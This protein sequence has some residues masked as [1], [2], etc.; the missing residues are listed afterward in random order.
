MRANDGAD[1]DDDYPS[2]EDPDEWNDEPAGAQDSSE[3]GNVESAT[4]P[5]TKGDIKDESQAYLD[6]LSEEAKKFSSLVEDDDESLLEDESVLESP[7]DKFDPYGTF[8]ESLGRLQQEQPQLY[9]QLTGVLAQED[10]DVLTQV[11][12]HATVQQQQQATQQTPAV[13]GQPAGA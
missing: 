7:L 9:S 13:E 1:I 11:V 12:Q 4:L 8:K 5:D 6:F 2:S 10:R 3:W